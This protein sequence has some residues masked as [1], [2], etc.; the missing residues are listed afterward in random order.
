[1]AT[2][3]S[4]PQAFSTTLNVGGGVNNSQT[5]GLVLTSVTGLPTD[6]GVLC[7]DWASTLD[8]S[9]AEWIEYTGITGNELTGVTRGAEGYS[10]KAHGNGAVVA[11]V[12][13]QAHIK[14]LK[15]KLDGT[16]TAGAAL[17]Q[18]VDTSGNEQIILAKTTSAVN[19]LTVTNAATAGAPSIGATGGDTNISLSIFGKGSG[20]VN[21]S[22]PKFTLGSDAQG[23]VFFRNSSGN[24]A[25]LAPGTSGYFLKTNGATADPSW[26]VSSGGSTIQTSQVSTIAS[27]NTS[28]TSY[29]DSGLTVTFTPTASSNVLILLDF[30]WYNSGASTNSAQIMVDGVAVGTIPCCQTDF[31]TASKATNVSAHLIQ[32]ALTNASHTITIQYK[33]SAN[34]LNVNSGRLSV[35]PWV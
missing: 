14:R 22:S 1:M 24:I 5:T 32:T 9:V 26:A 34:T 4:V 10:A 3:Y 6:G 30:I 8:T 2:V 13:S 28:S 31:D 7:F 27:V 19:E 12:I 33:A 29:T 15:D 11:G 16:D 20:V 35:I 23:D 18:I 17:K 25:R 21:V